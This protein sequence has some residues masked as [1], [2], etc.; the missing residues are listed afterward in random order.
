MLAHKLLKIASIFKNNWKL[1]VGIALVSIFISIALFCPLFINYSTEVIKQR[2]SEIF[3]APSGVHWFGTDEFGRDVFRR[4]IWGTRFVLYVGVTSVALG[5]L[6][7]VPLGML[8][9]YWGGWRDEVLMRINDTFLSFPSIMLALLVIAGLGSNIF[10][11]IL[12]IAI[13][14]V[15]RISRVMRSCVISLKNE[16]FVIA[17]RARGE[18]DFYIVFREILPNTIGPITVEGGVRISYAIML[19]ASLS[20]LGMG[21]QQPQPDWGLLIFEARHQIFLA[22]WTLIFPSAA[23]IALILCFN[24][25]GDGLREHF[26]PK[27]TYSFLRI[28]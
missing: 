27:E 28:M 17:A 3:K 19:G 18:S 26:D 9:G 12:A 10:N 24:V 4:V 20:F 11:A 16:H 13:T 1:G 21:A 15:P 23:L 5:L 2:A 14:F 7:G 22:P 6:I 8:S 25:L